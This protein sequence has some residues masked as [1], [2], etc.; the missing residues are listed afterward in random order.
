MAAV[1][2]ERQRTRPDEVQVRA[3]QCCQRGYTRR[4]RQAR[5]VGPASNL[6]LPTLLCCVGDPTASLDKASTLCG[7]ASASQARAGTQ[8]CLHMF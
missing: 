7:G 6:N 8:T 2:L 4:R 5:S 1:E 3:Q